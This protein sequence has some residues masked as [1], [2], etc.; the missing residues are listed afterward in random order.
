MFLFEL[1]LIFISDIYPRLFRRWT[2]DGKYDD[3]FTFKM[4]DFAK[5]FIM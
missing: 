4:I 1:H 2:Y 5:G 3:D